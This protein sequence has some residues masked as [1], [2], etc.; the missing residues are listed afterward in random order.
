MQ[1]E[2]NR[3]IC[4]RLY[5]GH[6]QNEQFMYVVEGIKCIQP[7]FNSQMLM[8]GASIF[9]S[10]AVKQVFEISAGQNDHFQCICDRWF[11]GHAWNKRLVLV[12]EGVRCIVH[13]AQVR[14]S[15]TFDWGSYV[16]AS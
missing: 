5:R 2:H 8:L 11:F 4:N 3:G 6:A 16:L 12:V 13:S 14:C 1:N 15:D 9:R 10:A 7:K